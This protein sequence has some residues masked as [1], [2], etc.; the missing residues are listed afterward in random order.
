MMREHLQNPS[1]LHFGFN[2]NNKNIFFF[3]ED[4]SVFSVWLA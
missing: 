2:N 1:F 3:I 4:E